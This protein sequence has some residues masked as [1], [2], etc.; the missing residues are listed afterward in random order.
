MI[1]T[2]V[3]P[4]LYGI[5]VGPG[6]PELLTLKGARI[7]RS[8]DVIFTVI[9]AHADDSVSE[10]I[11]LS[12]APSARIQRLVFSMSRDKAEREAV[13][14]ANAARI[15]AELEA[16]RAVAFTTIG[17]PMTYSTYGYILAIVRQALPDIAVETVPGITSYSTLTARTGS[18]LVEN[19][20]TLRVIPA[21]KAKDAETISFPKGTSTVL[22]KTYRS[23]AALIARLRQEPDIE[24]LYGE[25][26]TRRDEFFSRDLDEIAA[27]PECYLSLMLVRHKA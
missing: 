1:T 21:F 16:G 24:V 22:L 10:S 2:S 13:V 25:N 3:C 6:D 11:V 12:V 23:R 17:D 26:L 27:R 9:S 4:R 5:G 15:I 7:L 19:T 8:C 20:E 18:I 14:A